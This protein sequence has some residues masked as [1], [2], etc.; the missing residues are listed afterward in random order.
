MENNFHLNLRDYDLTI[1]TSFL[2]KH[3]ISGHVFEEIEYYWLVKDSTRFKPCI[4]LSD[5]T[6]KEEFSIA[7]KNKY[8]NI[9]DILN[10]VFEHPGP[11]LLFTNNILFVD[12]SWRGLDR[13]QIFANNV[14]IFRCA[15]DNFDY[16]Y[17]NFEKV[18]LLQD[19]EVY[20]EQGIDYNKKI[21]F[22]RLKDVGAGPN[23]NIAMLY[24]TS[25][26]RGLSQEEVDRVTKPFGDYVV[27]TNTA[28]RYQNSYMVPVD[29]LWE[30]FDTYVYTSIPKQWDCSSRFIKECEYFGRDVIYAID[31]DDRALKVRINNTLE[32]VELTPS[33]EFVKILNAKL[34]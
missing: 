6:T 10:H 18:H 17:K 30:K 7:L 5:G 24:L 29:N 22:S 4:L 1:T 13:S 31:Y 26:C 27:F 15:E 23:K 14:F 2:Y 28:E 3:G 8:K 25:N 9:D 12:G 16:F 20:G 21:M 33:D 32:D 34:K 11:K 19:Y